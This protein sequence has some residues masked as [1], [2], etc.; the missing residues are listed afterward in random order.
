MPRISF[1]RRVSTILVALLVALTCSAVANANTSHAGWPEID[2]ML[3]MNKLD[4]SR[5]LDGRPGQDPFGGTDPAYSCDG[6]HKSSECIPGLPALATSVEGS[7]VIPA[8]IGHNELLGGHGNDTIYA[9]PAGDVLWGDYKP[10]GQPSTQWDRL[11]GGPGNDFIYASHGTNIIDTG[12]GRDV[13]HAHFGR[14]KIHCGSAA[15]TLFISR[16]SRPR[17]RISG[18]RRISYKTLGY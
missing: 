7:R 1:S 3:L 4:Q 17:Y 16:K 2:G 8:D 10:S 14:G 18:C 6:L 13:V 5:P 15:T 11:T 9:G 12:L